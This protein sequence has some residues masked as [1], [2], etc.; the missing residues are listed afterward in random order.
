YTIPTGDWGDKGPSTDFGEDLYFATMQQ[1]LKIDE[2]IQGHK[3]VMDKYDP[4]GRV[5]LMVDEW[6]IWTNP[7]PGTNPGFLEQQNSLRDALVASSTLDI[8]NKH[9]DR[10]RMAN[11]AQMLNVLQAMIL[12]RDEQMIKTP[13]Y[14]VF[15]MYKVHHDAMLLSSA[16]NVVD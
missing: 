16:K 10:V 5:G 2:Y 1:A 15:K 9:S 7:L 11:I 14:Y 12:T 6:G 13:T 4:E 8:L 3:T